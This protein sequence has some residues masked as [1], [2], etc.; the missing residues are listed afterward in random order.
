ML[1]YA[2]FLAVLL[3]GALLIESSRVKNPQKSQLIFAGI[4]IVLFWGSV[5]ARD[6]GTDVMNY[7]NNA[8]R[9][10]EMGYSAYLD[11]TKF[12]DGYATLVWLV[13]H[14]FKNPQALLFI[15]NA[16]VTYSVFR[17]IYRNSKDVFLSLAAYVCV[18]SFSMFLYA[19]RQAFA[20]AICLFAL[21]AI[22][23]NKKV[24]AVFLILFSTL[25]HQTAL[26]FLP[27]VFLYGRKLNSKNVF[28]FSVFMLIIAFSLD[29]ILP[30]ANELFEMEYG[31]RGAASAIGG[32]IN[33]AIY[34]FAFILLYNKY[35]KPSEFK[36]K[37]L[38]KL[39][40]IVYLAITAFVIYICRFYAL[41]MER[42]A[43]YFLPAF[44][45][46]WA[47]ALTTHEGKRIKDLPALF[48]LLSVALFLYRSNTSMGSYNC[49]WW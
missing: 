44:C 15:Q 22:Q 18:G 4:V 6:F 7:Y 49:V 3:G 24:L 26:V 16:F 19:F 45:I 23:K 10:G 9:A 43:H 35:K 33:V 39:S 30:S 31:K 46:I 21:E 42:V 2:I 37:E 32:L 12:E 5:D 25:F 11:R 34:I 36:E 41:A 8:V 27:V 40:I 17:F 14:I 28:F 13:A 20:I 29:S 47:D 48:V 1:T 38:D